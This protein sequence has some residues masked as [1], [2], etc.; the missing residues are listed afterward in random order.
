MKAFNQSMLFIGFFIFN[1]SL[2]Y[3]QNESICKVLN[4][5]D[6]AVYVG[7]CKKGLANGKGVLK[8]SDGEKIYVGNFKKG[9]MHGEGELFSLN[10][11]QKK[12]I[13]KGVWQKNVF[14]GEKKVRPYKIKKSIN[15]G[16]YS[17]RKVGDDRNKIKF[18]FFQ[19]GNRNSVENLNIYGDSG[20][21]FGESFSSNNSVS[22]IEYKI[23]FSCQVNYRTL[24]K[25][26]GQDYL[27]QFE[28]IINEPGH[29]EVILNN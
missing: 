27:V 15:V 22:Y 20:I 11:G 26:K 7:K 12:S 24:S 23:P 28:I 14:I 16:R 3:S 5:N 29:W 1:V 10:N 21:K 9:K 19:N 17:I 4:N 8:Y 13:K 2:G 25:L 18:S 6:S